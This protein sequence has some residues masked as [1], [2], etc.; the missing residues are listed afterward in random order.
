[1]STTWTPQPR[2]WTVAI[3]MVTDGPSGSRALD[4]VA[5]NELADIIHAAIPQDAGVPL[6]DIHIAVQLDFSDQNGILRLVVDGDVQKIP[7]TDAT[8]PATLNDFF[9]WVADECPAKHYAVNF[10]GAQLRPGRTVRRY[11]DRDER[12]EPPHTA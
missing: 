3:Y 5:E 8:A 7:E 1:M 11:S 6:K 12:P 2:E 9:R 4:E 10:S